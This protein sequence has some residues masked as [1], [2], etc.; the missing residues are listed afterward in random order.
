MFTE[1]VSA[2]SIRDVGAED[3]AN[4]T[5]RASNS[6]GSDSYTA[7]LVVTDAPKI[8]PFAFPIDEQL[9]K[10]VTVSCFRDAG[11]PTAQVLVAQGR[12]SSR[13]RRGHRGNR[14]QDVHSDRTETFQRRTSAT[15]PA[16]F[17]TPPERT[18]SRPR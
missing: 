18:N 15:T 11:T 7:E 10:D 4:Y 9:G 13:P 14:R 2:L 8:Q 16:A 17:P 5:C 12:R 3:V 6:A 1:S